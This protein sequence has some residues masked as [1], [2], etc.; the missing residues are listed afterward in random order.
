LKAQARA[1]EVNNTE[2]YLAL[3][4]RDGS[5]RVFQ[6]SYQAPFWKEISIYVCKHQKIP[7]EWIE[8]LKFSPDGKYLLVSSHNNFSYL[9]EVPNFDK[10]VK[11]FG[12]SSS[13]ITHIDWSLDS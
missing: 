2:E 7:A 13:Y 1:I 5:V 3:G 10:P 4:M 6:V 12:K 11:V 8:D 9:F